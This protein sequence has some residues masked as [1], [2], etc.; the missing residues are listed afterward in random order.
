M[1]GAADKLP[2]EGEGGEAAGSVG[3]AFAEKAR[4]GVGLPGPPRGFGFLRSDREASDQVNK[5]ISIGAEK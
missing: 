4:A 3:S 2:G 5:V 1:A